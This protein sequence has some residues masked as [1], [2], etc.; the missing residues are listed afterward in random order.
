[1]LSRL[2]VTVVCGLLLFVAAPH[3]QADFT[4]YSQLDDSGEMISQQPNFANTWIG[5]EIGNLFIGKDRLTITFAMKDLN[6]STALDFPAGGVALGTCPDCADLQRYNFT[7]A[8][9]TLLADSQ[10]HTFVVT[11]GT[12][13]LGIA[14]GSTPIYIT[15]FGLTQYHQSTHLKSNAAGTIP[16]L[17]VTT[18]N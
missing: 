16:Y 13:T 11:T 10:F 2:A 12:T 14:D 6:A 3:A 15:F 17:V 1:M 8:D 7:D 9:R 4:I 18:A 5:A